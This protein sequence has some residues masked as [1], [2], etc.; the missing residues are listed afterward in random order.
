MNT[1]VIQAAPRM[2]AGN[3]H[4]VLETFLKGYR[5]DNSKVE[6]IF[7]AKQD[8]KPCKGCFTCYA[9]TPGV[10]V[11]RDDMPE[12]AD[13]I[14]ASEIMILA[15]PVYLDGMTSLAKGFFDRLVCFLDPHFK[16]DELGLLHPLRRDFPQ[17]IFLLS[18][19]GYHGLYNF[20][21]LVTHMRRVAREFHAD[22]CGALL[23]PAIF[24]LLLAKQYPDE[25]KSVI[26][27]IGRA[28]KEL[29]ATGSVSEETLE[30]AARDICGREEL[31]R[32]ANAYWDREI[33]KSQ[34]ESRHK[35]V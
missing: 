8:I 25:V 23:R 34:A 19:C 17:K 12:L 20:D 27:A 32:I 16:I 2:K 9:K 7:L 3:T 28:G 22:Y 35:T 30:S 11:H 29:A 1:I 18:V 5:Q 15:T 26:D 33:T 24:S 6:T 21:P 31:A 4:M 14:Q 10:C 13:K